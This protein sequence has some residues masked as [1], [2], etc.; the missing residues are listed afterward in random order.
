MSTQNPR[1]V[2]ATTRSRERTNVSKLTAH[3]QHVQ[4]VVQVE[5]ER[6]NDIDDID[7]ST[8]VLELVGT[9]D[10]AEEDLYREPDV[11]HRLNDIEEGVRFRGV[12]ESSFSC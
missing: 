7:G 9:G 4:Y 11:T 2:R 8:Q 1:R 6:C 5:V 12:L 3:L 10:E